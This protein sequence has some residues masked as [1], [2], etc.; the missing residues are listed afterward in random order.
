[1]SHSPTLTEI[2]VKTITSAKW[3]IPG[4]IAVQLLNIL[5]TIVLSRLLPPEDFGALIMLTLISTY[6]GLV[7]NNVIGSAVTQNQQLDE[8]DY[9]SIFWMNVV[10]GLL[11][12]ILLIV[13]R[14]AIIGF[15]KQPML[16]GYIKLYAGIFICYAI[17]SVSQAILAKQHNFKQIVIGN[18]LGI[19]ISYAAAIIMVTFGWRVFSL[20]IQML[21]N[22][23]ISSLYFLWRSGW[24][25][26]FYFRL[27]SFGKI[28]KFSIN[29][30]LNTSLE[31]FSFNLDSFLVGRSFGRKELGLF[32]RSKQLVFLPVQ[33]IAFAIS[34]SFYPAFA[35]MQDHKE[36]LKQLYLSAIRITF[37]VTAS[38]ITYMVVVAPDLIRILMGEQWMG[39]VIMFQLFSVTGVLGTL[40]GFNDSFI[41]SQGRTDL[42]FRVGLF[43]KSFSLVATIVGISY[44]INGII[45]ARLISSLVI[46]IPKV[47]LLLYVIKMSASLFFKNIFNT[48]FINSITLLICW[49]LMKQLDGQSSYTRFCLVSLTF[50]SL[51]ILLSAVMKEKGFIT[52]KNIIKKNSSRQ[53]AKA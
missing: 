31:Y 52:I 35:Q 43:E 53:H 34:R 25:P 1:M 42:L 41:S 10:L 8:K 45:Y 51:L 24:R 6:A 13:F 5:G 23:T 37:Y 29:L 3:N 32:G 14:D 36:E 39:M 15:Y 16:H 50:V 27:A 44:G 22:V 40:N 26:G 20:V 46:F 48:F 28:R 9:S 7:M 19:I 2:K 38:V 17:G 47:F 18:L 49:M 21:L 4:Q 11:F 12:M 33:N 30:F